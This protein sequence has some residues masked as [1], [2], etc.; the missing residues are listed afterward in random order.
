MTEFNKPIFVLLVE[1]NFLNQKLICLNLAKYGFEIDIANNGKEA[2]EKISQ[3]H[4]NNF[5]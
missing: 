3:R 1:D 4:R 2:L 5:V